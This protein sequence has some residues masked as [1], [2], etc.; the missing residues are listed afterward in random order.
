MERSFYQVFR[1]IFIVII[2]FTIFYVGLK[3][4]LLVISLL[5]TFYADPVST[6]PAP[7]KTYGPCEGMY[8]GWEEGRF[9]GH[10]TLYY[11]GEKKKINSEKFQIFKYQCYAKDDKSVFFQGS[12]IYGAD[13]ASFEAIAPQ[14]GKDK[15][16]GYFRSMPVDGSCGTT[17]RALDTTVSIFSTDGID[18]FF[19]NRAM[20]VVDTGN[21]RIIESCGGGY[22]ST[23]GKYAYYNELKVPSLDINTVEKLNGY[24]QIY[25]DKNWVYQRNRKLNYDAH[26]KWIIDTID[27]STFRI[28]NLD[29]NRGKD[30]FGLIEVF[31]GRL[32]MDSLSRRCIMA[33][34]KRRPP[35][36]TTTVE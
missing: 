19:K 31:R 6:D 14:H 13:A 17:F 2:A 30:K 28:I 12:K 5:R 35:F 32:G 36:N 22:I 10:R 7:N 1:K 24:H 18:F 26:G 23:D 11:D 21:F 34:K 3:M 8:E 29:G 15:Y 16:K 27:A 33:P 25:K 4:I 9:R 20:H